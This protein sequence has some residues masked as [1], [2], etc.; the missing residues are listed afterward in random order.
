MRISWNSIRV[1][2][3]VGYNTYVDKWDKEYQRVKKGSTNAN[4]DAFFEINAE[5]ER[6]SELARNTFKQFEVLGETPTADE[7]RI[8]F[9]K[10][11]GKHTDIKELQ[12]EKPISFYIDQFCLQQ[13]KENSWTDAT[14]AKIKGLKK[15]L[16]DYSPDLTLNQ[17][18]TLFLQ[19]YT[20]YLLNVLNMKNTTVNKDLKLVNWFLKWAEKK[21]HLTCKDY[22][23][24][25]PK[26]K[27]LKNKVVFLTWDELIK[28]YNTVYPK[29]KAH[30]ERVRDVF[31]FMC[32][33]SLRYSDIA[34]LRRVHIDKD[35]INVI[36]EKT[37]DYVRIN[38]NKYT[39]AILEK[40]KVEKF[41]NDLAL[42]VISN[43]KMN[44]FLKEAFFA[45]GIDS[46]VT[47]MYYKGVE[48]IEEVYPKY[49]AAT[50][51]MARRTF[52]YNALAMG[53]PPETVMRW[54]GHS[55]YKAMLPY[56][57]IADEE[58]AKAM[59]FFDEK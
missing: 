5:L 29:E 39:R 40:Y 32:F 24:Y 30:L 26:L 36:T 47:T 16:I 25:N 52:I 22:T 35:Y 54:T 13:G 51:H 15:H 42:P 33:S 28:L 12:Q 38:L 50:T 41:D 1:H 17:I 55:D 43:Q 31:C 44:V 58:K 9:N 21:G 49:E 14:Y 57:D 2:F 56:I 10:L 6:L 48:K 18:T 3:N 45:A 37:D 8:A 27:T 34:T 20:D 46:K 53:I 23:E 7:Y 19:G 4:G 59:K 11:N